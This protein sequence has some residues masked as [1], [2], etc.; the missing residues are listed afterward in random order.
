MNTPTPLGTAEQPSSSAAHVL[1]DL[2]GTRRT[3]PRVGQRV[4]VGKFGELR[5]AG[6]LVKIITRGVRQ[7]G[8]VEFEPTPREPGQ[9]SG[10]RAWPRPQQPIVRSF[11]LVRLYP[12]NPLCATD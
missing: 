3:L 5:P 1:A 12:E 6:L 9:R 11:P 7:Y 2:P 8:L 10:A 4:C